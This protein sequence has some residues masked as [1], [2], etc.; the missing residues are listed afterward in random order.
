M[1]RYNEALLTEK[2]LNHT[3]YILQASLFMLCDNV[4]EIANEAEPFDPY[5]TPEVMKDIADSLISELVN[6]KDTLKL[7]TAERTQIIERLEEL[8][9]SLLKFCESFYAYF[10]VNNLLFMLVT[11]RMRLIRFEGEKEIPVDFKFF[12]RDMARFIKRDESPKAMSSDMALMMK[13]LPLFMTKAKY[14]DYLDRSLD[15]LF[16]GES[17]GYVSSAVKN[18]KFKFLPLGFDNYGKYFP[19]L[20]DFY[21][22]KLNDNLSLLKI[23]DLDNL[24]GEIEDKA[25]VMD[26]IS[27]R[28]SILYEAINSTTLVLMFAKDLDYL[29]DFNPVYKDLFYLTVENIK[30]SPA[31]L[32]EEHV[33]E[34]FDSVCEGVMDKIIAAEKEGLLDIMA[35]KI[36]EYP[37]NIQELYEVANV[38]N[39]VYYEMLTDI[40]YSDAASQNNGDTPADKAFKDS[41]KM[42]IS[43]YMESVLGLVPARLQ[44]DIK[45]LFFD[46][47]PSPYTLKEFMD[48]ADY[49]MEN[50]MSYPKKICVMDEVGDIFEQMGFLDELDME[51]KEHNHRH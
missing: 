46:C 14:L 50:I 45:R 11:D 5:E 40:V 30:D 23:E 12:T 49:V 17:E 8:K 7:K 18:L 2:M 26:Q 10:P 9:L 34:M 25:H 38:V 6:M 36:G 4:R 27:D 20:R 33:D 15:L 37:Q 19:E 51:E 24:I 21:N 48:Y 43:A 28:L 44:K 3:K 32:M 31:E 29:F 16:D 35:E 22:G 1:K 41:A 42:G 13:C 47:I 39:N